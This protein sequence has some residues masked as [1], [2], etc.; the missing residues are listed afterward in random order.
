MAGGF[1]LRV[2]SGGVVRWGI[3][4]LNRDRVPAVVYIHPPEFDREKPRLPLP[5]R[6]RILHYH[7]LGTVEAKLEILLKRFRFVTVRQLLG[8]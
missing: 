6:E 1:Y 8:L 3:E 4:R 5:L 2:L 7:G